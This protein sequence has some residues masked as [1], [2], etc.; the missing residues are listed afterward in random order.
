MF[1]VN[2]PDKRFVN[3]TI[4]TIEDITEYEY[5]DEPN[6][7]EV[8]V[9]IGDH[10][11]II[12]ITTHTWEMREARYNDKEKVMTSE[13]TGSFEQLPIRLAWA[14]TI[15]KAQGKTFDAMIIDA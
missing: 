3:G 1:V 10:S 13:V 9:H 4:G 5:D 2:D 6:S 14:C 11:E 15:H 8:D 12:T 7:L